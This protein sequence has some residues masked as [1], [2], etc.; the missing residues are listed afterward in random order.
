M[1][2]HEKIPQTV[3]KPFLFK[4]RLI[5]VYVLSYSPIFWSSGERQY[6]Y[7]NSAYIISVQS[8]CNNIDTDI[9]SIFSW[10]KSRVEISRYALKYNSI[11]KC[12]SKRKCKSVHIF[13]HGDVMNSIQT[14]ASQQQSRHRVQTHHW[15]ATNKR[16]PHWSIENNWNQATGLAFA[17]RAAARTLLTGEV[18]GVEE[19]ELEVM[20][21]E[22]HCSAKCIHFF[23]T[24]RY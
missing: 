16:W 24:R 13:S 3:V 9:S 19:G 1:D 12:K 7:R 10:R 21:G 17:V 6:I 14:Q 8:I 5:D 18:V 4:V 20:G 22:H 23:Y 11:S 15:K 2:N